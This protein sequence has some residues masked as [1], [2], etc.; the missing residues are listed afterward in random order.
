MNISN[1]SVSVFSTFEEFHAAAG[2][3]GHR[4][5]HCAQLLRF[6]TPRMLV[7]Q[8]VDAQLAVIL[9]SC[10]TANPILRPKSVKN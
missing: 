5:G 9:R 3:I 6:G 4:L 7:L 10:P 1:F 2:R 8:G